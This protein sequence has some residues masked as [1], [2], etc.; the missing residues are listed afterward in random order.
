MFFDKLEDVRAI[1][2]RTGC[3]VFVVPSEMEV[4]IKG[5]LVLKPE[6]KTV[7]TIEQVRDVT[8]KLATKQF[9]DIYVLI[10][11]AD[12][13][14]LDAANAFLKNLEEPGEH[15]HYILVTDK[16]SSILP[17]ILSRSALYILRRPALLEREFMADAEVK[18]MAKRLM[19]AKPAEIPAV[20]EDITKKKE[21]AKERALAVLDA[22][23]E[24]LYRSYFITGKDGFVKK[25]PKF[26]AA[27][28]AISRNGH[29]K[30]HLVADLI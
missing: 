8:A 18:D 3:A 10:R 7:I 5:A 2:E 14:G 24:M 30:L 15:V 21:G 11:P 6:G 28:E 27:H 9:D 19:V 16:P 22:A 12:L 4:E 23:I 20:V 29:V 25:I 13:L 26:L 1:V 17:T